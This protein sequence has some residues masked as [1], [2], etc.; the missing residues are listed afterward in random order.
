MRLK[1]ELAPKTKFYS[2]PA[3]P[4]GSFGQIDV[5]AQ[6][7]FKNG[8]A[9]DNARI[10]LNAF[11]DPAWQ[12]EYVNKQLKGRFVPVYKDQIKD[13]LWTKND[14][15]SEYQKI[16]ES[17]RIMSFAS[18]PLGGIAELTT[19][20][21]IGDMMQDLLVKRQKPNEALA[22]FVKGAEEIYNK[23]ENRR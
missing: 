12:N 22:S 13:D 16:I 10:L 11:M 18:A 20:F 23:P 14:L 7:L 4:A 5:W 2:Y 19:K 9:G 17:G 15:Y 21:L 6:V 8:K 1:P 3:G